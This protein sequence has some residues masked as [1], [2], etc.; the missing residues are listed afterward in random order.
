MN[1]L[2]LSQ[3]T[4]SV[5]PQGVVPEPTPAATPLALTRVHKVDAIAER[6]F[7]VGHSVFTVLAI[8]G[9]AF[10]ILARGPN[11][12]DVIVSGVADGKE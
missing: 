1:S 6:T 7:W 12:R 11:R 9:L 10:I 8:V 5:L 4:E 2:E 3:A